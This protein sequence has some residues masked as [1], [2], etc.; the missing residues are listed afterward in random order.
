MKKFFVVSNKSVTKSVRESLIHLARSLKL[1]NFQQR[2]GEWINHS[3]LKPRVFNKQSFQQQ[4][5]LSNTKKK[6]DLRCK[7]IYFYTPNSRTSIILTWSGHELEPRPCEA[8]FIALTTWLILQ[9]C[10]YILPCFFFLQIFYEISLRRT[11]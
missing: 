9:I 6:I 11:S 2:L 5:F 7:L 8:K 1:S 10:R 4:T 3:N